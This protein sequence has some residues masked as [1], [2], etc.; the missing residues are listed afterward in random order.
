MSPVSLLLEG[1]LS[2]KKGIKEINIRSLKQQL[3]TCRHHRA[4]CVQYNV[5]RHERDR[6]SMFLF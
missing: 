4:V 6:Q 2:L 5:L 3:K 1:W